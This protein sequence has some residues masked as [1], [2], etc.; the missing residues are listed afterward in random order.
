MESFT[1]N[2]RG[3]GKQRCRNIGLHSCF[4]HLTQSPCPV[5]LLRLQERRL[6]ASPGCVVR[7][8]S[9]RFET[10][11]GLS[12][13]T[14]E[15]WLMALLY[16]FDARAMLHHNDLLIDWHRK[17]LSLVMREKLR[18]AVGYDK[19]FETSTTRRDLSACQLVGQMDEE[20]SD[21]RPAAQSVRSST[22]RRERH[23]YGSATRPSDHS[24]RCVGFKAIAKAIRLGVIA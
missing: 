16:S 15:R 12:G 10:P 22:C 1:R 20:C 5:I 11:L 21:R 4:S 3:S 18:L 7:T 9:R 2:R 19:R 17:V 13:S 24:S 8:D 23:D 6:R 14:G